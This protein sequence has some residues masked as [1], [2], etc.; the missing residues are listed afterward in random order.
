MNLLKKLIFFV[1]L[2]S[3]SISYAQPVKVLVIAINGIETAK[4]EWQPTIEYL[5]N[6]MPQHSFSLV[7]LPPSDLAKIKDLIA[8]NEIDFVI[9]QPAIY[10]DLEINFG[11]SRILTM[12]KKG[13]LSEFG[14]TIITHAD[15]GI[16]S[17]AELKGKTI[18][19]VAKLGF[20]GWLV[21]Y[22]EMLVHGFDPY[23]D[24]KKV[25][26]LGTQIKEV[27]AVLQGTIDAAVIRTGVL[28][29]LS[30]KGKVKLADLK[31]L[32]PKKYT[33][34]PL[35]VSTSLYPEWVFAKSTKASNEL[36]KSVAFSLLSIKGD[37][38]TAQKAGYL[39][40]TFPYDYQPVHKLLQE[41]QVGPYKHYGKVTTIDF[42][43]QYLAEFIL[44]L[45]LIV[46]IFMMSISLYRSNRI[47][48]K[49]KLEKEQL[50]ENIKNSE[51]QYKDAQELAGLGHWVLDLETNQLHW[52][53]EIYR[54]FEI[55]AEQFKATYEGFV[56]TIHPDD[57]EFVNK[58]YTDSISNR[59]DYDIEH[60][61]L[62]QDG[63]IKYV[64]EHCETDYNDDGKPLKSMG[65]VLDIT[66]RKLTELALQESNDKFRALTETTQDFIWEVAAD[67]VYTY[68]SPQTIDI[69]GYR[70][71][72]LLGKSPMDIMSKEE[73]ERVGAFF[74][75]VVAQQ[76][77]IKEFE[78]T[79]LTKQGREVIL[80][81]SGQP[82]FNNRGELQGYRGIDRD[83]THRKQAERALK[84]SEAR[85]RKLFEKTDAISVQGYNKD[86]QVIYWNS[87]SE[88]LY[89]YSAEDAIG[90]K[91]EDLI[92]PN[93]MQDQV[94]AG[95]DDW[96]NGGKE[97][98]SAELT[99]QKADGTPVHVFS[100]HVMLREQSNDPEIYCIDIDISVRKEQ[101][102]KIKHQAFFDSLTDLPNRSLVLD[103]LTQLL[104][105]AK[106]NNEKVAVLFL[107]L[108]D[109][110]KINDTLGHETGDKLLIESAERLL[111]VI[112]TGDTVGRLGGDEFIILLG[113][114]SSSE[115]AQPIAE[116]LLH[117]FRKLFK[118]DSRELRLT[119]S[120]G[121]ATYPDDGYD[122]SKLLRNADSA[123]YN[124]KEQGRNT[125]S[126]FTDSMNREV[127]RRLALEE[128]IHGALTHNEF[129]I[130]YQPKIEISSGNIIGAEALLRWHNS[131]LGDVSPMEFIPICEQTGLIIP[132]GKFVLENALK[133]TLQWQEINHSDFY[134]AVNL[135][136]SQF[137]DPGLVQ[138]I[139]NI[140]EKT[141]IS[142][143][144]LELEI[145]EGVLM[146][147]YNYVDK[148]LTSLSNMGITI[149][150]D[151]FG[152]GYSS[153]SYLRRY[154]FN[155]LKIDRSFI[156]GITI[157]CA[158]RELINA[159]IVMAHALNIK[160][161][162]EGVE[163]REQL[164]LL[165]QMNCDIAQGYFFSKPVS[166]ADFTKL[167]EIETSKFG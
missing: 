26:F 87:A 89:G 11:V 109:F 42:I 143:R 125:Y 139:E 100:S 29:S 127:S 16:D 93:E 19:G 113:G 1:L 151:D 124:A 117:Q 122:P 49:G 129:E 55:N 163:T 99:L 91:L 52:S 68:C 20:G 107:D 104:N 24:A 108:D 18:A 97:V 28:E 31:I 157:G 51:K 148:A 4:L 82:F 111:S 158:D 10:I 95:I 27:N 60:R 36:S 74:K 70:P 92:I 145:T 79:N 155:V 81:T 14:S 114:L 90:K 83:I 40:W 118:I 103:R 12:V 162:A 66:E 43:K 45:I 94:R 140:L 119:V 21:G 142:T 17:I 160:V 147:C 7:P 8:N 25:I 133:Q 5:Q 62:M 72:E 112:R 141:K 33:H 77:P 34:F 110:K 96:I 15:S 136:P 166:A 13:G 65:T 144:Y 123:M 156:D 61:L 121:I 115:E 130:Y 56:N 2:L 30:K 48:S 69:L 22:K 138:D 3:T 67:G 98:P 131:V 23:S 63:R 106:R 149:A 80:E 71:E 88:T 39:E 78:N 47:L 132:I 134:I 53:D 75:K 37:S 32:S 86:H 116:N 9:S 120:I 58:A 59:A 85:F 101:D 126:Y 105:E 64:H 35:H 73:A 165:S 6:S 38:E 167:L 137:R 153:L 102:D 76:A 84:E 146:S 159:A 50:L 164:E 46:I 41:L 54:I 154:P 135:S 161:V 150:M 57:R 128:Q 152:T 44:F